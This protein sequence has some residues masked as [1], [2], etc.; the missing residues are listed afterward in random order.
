MFTLVSLLIYRLGC[1]SAGPVDAL[2][3]DRR[4]SEDAVQTSFASYSRDVNGYHLVRGGT[5]H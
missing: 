1:F 2:R 5:A 4:E 3:L